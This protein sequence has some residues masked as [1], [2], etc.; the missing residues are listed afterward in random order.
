MDVIRPV[1]GIPN[2]PWK[3]AAIKFVKNNPYIIKLEVKNLCY[4]CDRHRDLLKMFDEEKTDYENS[5]YFKY[6]IEKSKK[7]KKVALK[8]IHKYKDLYFNMK[9][10]ICELPKNKLPI[11]T[12]DGCRLDG[13]H[14]L[15]ILE[16][17]NYEEA[18]VNIVFYNKIFSK[19]EIKKILKDN[20]NYRKEVYN[21]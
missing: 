12:E 4:E 20:L 8:K 15:T 9:K 3:K 1:I 19:K 16:H 18:D 7:T 2:Y 13:S 6:S 5:I 21:L 17:L 10:V 11:I 14:K